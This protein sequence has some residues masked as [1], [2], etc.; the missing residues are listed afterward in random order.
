MLSILTLCRLF[1]ST[2]NTQ[3]SPYP[4]EIQEKIMRSMKGLGAVEIV[5][6]GYD[7]EYD[8]VNPDLIFCFGVIPTAGGVYSAGAEARISVRNGVSIASKV[9]VGAAL[10]I[11]RTK[12]HFI[13]NCGKLLES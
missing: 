4:P 6:P 9:K 5:R 13:L 10:K 2:S 3:H 12:E 8:F 1:F 7:V 11:T